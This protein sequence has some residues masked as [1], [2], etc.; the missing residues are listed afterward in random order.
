MFGKEP[1]RI[2][3]AIS[4]GLILATAFGLKISGEQINYILAFAAAIIA[5]FGAE[6]IRSQVTPT[7]TANKQI[8]A[9]IDAPKG[10]VEVSDI[11]QQVKDEEINEN[12]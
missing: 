10:S 11:V 9:G 1:A 5:L 6:A 4:A 3:G 8:Q 12:Q 2:L 7:A